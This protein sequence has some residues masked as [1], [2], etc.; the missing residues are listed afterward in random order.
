M[1]SNTHPNVRPANLVK[2]PLMC[3]RC[4]RGT[5][6]DRQCKRW[7]NACGYVESCEDNFLPLEATPQCERISTD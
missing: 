4:Q 1:H 3:P 6:N 2:P 5:L 7:C